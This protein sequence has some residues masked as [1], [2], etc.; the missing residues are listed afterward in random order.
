MSDMHH[1]CPY[2]G[3]EFDDETF[4]CCGERGHG[5]SLTQ[6]QFDHYESSG[7]YI[8]DALQRP[9]A[10]PDYREAWEYHADNARIQRRRE[11]HGI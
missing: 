1:L 6:K 3:A 4:T 2:C 11:L 7:C 5:V 8:G 9:D 10:T